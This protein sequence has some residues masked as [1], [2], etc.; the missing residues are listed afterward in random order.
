MFQH[1]AIHQRDSSDEDD[2]PP[3]PDAGRQHPSARVSPARQPSPMDE[4][5][6]CHEDLDVQ[7]GSLVPFNSQEMDL[8][9][10]QPNSWPPSPDAMDRSH[11]PMDNEI[12]LVPATVEGRMVINVSE[13]ES[14]GLKRR[15]LGDSSDGDSDDDDEGVTHEVEMPSAPEPRPMEVDAPSAA[16]IGAGPGSAPVEDDFYNVAGKAPH[17][18]AIVLKQESGWWVAREERKRRK[19][20]EQELAVLQL[21]EVQE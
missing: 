16:L 3:H 13:V 18:D 19:V 9:A 6:E 10:N 15:L 8:A 11:A 12:A 20:Q 21:C 2:T 5:K 17:P 14:Y 1:V 7:S 4:D